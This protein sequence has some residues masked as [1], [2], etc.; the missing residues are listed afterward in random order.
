MCR[1]VA[2][3]VP[4]PPCLLAFEVARAP[5]DPATA[6]AGWRGTVA[7]VAAGW[8]GRA[9]GAHRWLRAAATNRSRG[10]D[11]SYQPGSTGWARP[12]PTRQTTTNRTATNANCWLRQTCGRNPR[13]SHAD[14][15]DVLCPL[16]TIGTW[17]TLAKS[18]DCAAS[19]APFGSK[20]LTVLRGYLMFAA[21]QVAGGW[22]TEPKRPKYA[23]WNPGRPARP[24]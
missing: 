1:S 20:G 10:P 17:Q 7:L 2:P 16:A 18:G 24:H 21:I 3:T 5:L 19:F 11:P 12:A 6:I 8:R 4:N 22:T 14:S 15:R 23:R 13:R 9:S